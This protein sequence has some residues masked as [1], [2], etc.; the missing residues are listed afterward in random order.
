MRQRQACL[1]TIWEFV[2]N[3]MFRNRRCVTCGESF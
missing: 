3:L 2:G 1:H